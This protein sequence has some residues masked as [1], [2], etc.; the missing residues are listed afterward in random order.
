MNKT[1]NTYAIHHFASSW[2]DEG[3]KKEYKDIE[4]QVKMDRILHAP[5]RVLMR[6][7]GEKKYSKLK[8]LLG[9]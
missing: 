8:K 3:R 7:L 2:W 5:N 4:R 9:K 1:H 6:L